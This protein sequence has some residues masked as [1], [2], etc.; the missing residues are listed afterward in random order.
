MSNNV[1]E[2]NQLDIVSSNVNDKMCYICMDD[3]DIIKTCKC[4]GTMN[5]VHRKCLEKW[6]KQSKNDHCIVCNYKYKFELIYSP[7]CSRC[8]KNNIDCNNPHFSNNENII[9]LIILLLFI[10]SLIVFVIPVIIST[11]YIPIICWVCFILEVILLIILKK[12]DKDI[13]LWTILKYWQLTNSLLIYFYFI[14]M[15]NIKKNACFTECFTKSELCNSN[16]EYYSTYIEEKNNFFNGI[17]HQSII[18]GSVLL[19]I[20]IKDI[21][22]YK[23][24]KEFKIKS[25][26]IIPINH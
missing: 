26:Y 12:Y 15:I 3:N 11:Y 25:N 8:I 18:F 4:K 17:I 6:I 7:S 1:I 14:L 10:P 16:C 24:I 23:S 2:E 9:V 20:I 19:I 5:G 13:Y 21:F 22:C